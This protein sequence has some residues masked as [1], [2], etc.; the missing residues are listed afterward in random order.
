M[1]NA[2]RELRI[3]S[4]MDLLRK[5]VEECNV[6]VNE[7]RDRLSNYVLA[8]KFENK[9]ESEELKNVEQSAPLVHELNDVSR[10]IGVI[11]VNITDIMKRLEI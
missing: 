5:M 10:N 7:L 1:G 11:I 4:E 9:K 2:Q 3:L 6:C 8:P